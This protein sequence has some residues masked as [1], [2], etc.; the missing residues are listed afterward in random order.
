MPPRIVAVVAQFLTVSWR[1]SS[2]GRIRAFPSRPIEPTRS[3]VRRACL[4]VWWRLFPLNPTMRCVPRPF[5]FCAHLEIFSF[6]RTCTRLGRGLTGNYAVAR[7][8]A[9]TRTCQSESNYC[10]LSLHESLRPRR[11]L[12]RP[13]LVRRQFGVERQSLVR[14][15]VSAP[16]VAGRGDALQGGFAVPGGHVVVDDRV[17]IHIDVPI[18]VGVE[19]FAVAARPVVVAPAG[20]AADVPAAMSWASTSPSSSKSNGWAATWAS[21]CP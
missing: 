4:A 9:P 16:A 3:L 20:S 12:P 21:S 15:E 10:L 1:A 7:A 18:A 5:I 14:E 19:A 2:C 11:I 6:A 17:V 13:V 8:V